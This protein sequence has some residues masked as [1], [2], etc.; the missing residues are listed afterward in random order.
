MIAVTVAAVSL[1]MVLRIV[2][3]VTTYRRPSRYTARNTRGSMNSPPFATA[4]NA[5]ATC[6]GV[7]AT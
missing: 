2:L 6:S 1:L 3:G 4:L 7:T 5:A